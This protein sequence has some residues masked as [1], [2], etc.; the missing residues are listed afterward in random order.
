VGRVPVIMGKDFVCFKCLER[1]DPETAPRYSPTFEEITYPAVPRWRLPLPNA[2][3]RSMADRRSMAERVT[4][5]ERSDRLLCPNYHELPP[6]AETR[7]NIVVGV[8]GGPGVS[9][10]HYLCSLL[11]RV[12]WN[13]AL[14]SF[15]VTASKLDDHSDFRIRAMYQ[16]LFVDRQPIHLTRRL[17]SDEM[18]DPLGVVLDNTETRETANLLFFDLSGEQLQ[19]QAEMTRYARYIAVADGLLF[20]VDASALPAFRPSG[21]GL[22]RSNGL[23]MPPDAGFI[24]SAAQLRD[25]AWGEGYGRHHRTSVAVVLSKSDVLRGRD[26]L[27]ER[28]FAE[29]NYDN[30]PLGEHIYRIEQE[31]KLVGELLGAHASP[32]VA[33]AF[34]RFGGRPAFYAVSATGGPVVNGK[35]PK[36]EPVRCLDPLVK[37][38]YDARFIH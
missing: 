10:T 23:V 8:V 11:S 20:F 31:S 3:W 16:Q 22:G 30:M 5:A 7:R 34:N 37:I 36:V 9:K 33:N 2:R 24:D 17:G 27:A 6:H 4:D 25:Y 15:G 21:A 26:A 12:L 19:T 32:I 35:F 38:L 29:T 18:P 14:W 1:V 28:F 13:G